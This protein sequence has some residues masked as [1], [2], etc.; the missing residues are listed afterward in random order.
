[1]GAKY[2]LTDVKSQTGKLVGSDWL[3]L[4]DNRV[5]THWIIK[6]VFIDEPKLGHVDS[7]FSLHTFVSLVGSISAARLV[8]APEPARPV[9]LSDSQLR[10]VMVVAR[11]LEPEKRSVLLQRIAARLDLNGPVFTDR[12]LD[13]AITSALAGLIHE[14][15]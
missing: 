15:A 11:P 3:P 8:S 14:P 1:M 10:M 6:F 13:Q 9:G 7:D 4:D 5:V 2:Y 12:D